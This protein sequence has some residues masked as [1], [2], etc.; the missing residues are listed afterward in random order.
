MTVTDF[1]KLYA[2]ITRSLKNLIQEYERNLPPEK[3]N[4]LLMF[5]ANIIENTKENI[6]R[7]PEGRL[8][9]E[10]FHQWVDAEVDR[11]STTPISCKKGC[12]TCCHYEVEITEEEALLLAD[13]IQQGHKID[14]ARLRSQAGK[15]RQDSTWKLG[16]FKENRCVFL[17]DDL[18]CTIYSYRPT[19][20]RR[21]AVTSPAEN[22]ADFSKTPTVRDL[23]KVDIMLSA[24]M[25]NKKTKFGSL[26]KMLV[27]ELEARSTKGQMQWP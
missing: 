25:A 7:I 18:T 3:F 11:A 16:A 5:V 9:A 21:M 1:L 17:G 27:A 2:P 24:L 15:S 20:C 13:L 23:P 22:C 6:E 4:E 14:T 10:T 19:T 8:R 26:A 12:A